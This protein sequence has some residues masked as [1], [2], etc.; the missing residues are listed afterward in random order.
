MFFIAIQ[1]CKDKPKNC[2]IEFSGILYPQ[3]D[4]AK[5]ILKDN[6]GGKNQIAR[7]F[8][9]KLHNNAMVHINNESGLLKLDYDLEEC[10]FKI[11]HSDNN[12]FEVLGKV[13]LL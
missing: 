6:F 2:I 8:I 1:Q 7:I 11:F 10:E 12:N 4:Y 3:R 5:S 13:T 9:D